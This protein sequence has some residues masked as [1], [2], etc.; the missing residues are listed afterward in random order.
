MNTICKHSL[1]FIVSVLLP[2]NVIAEG[3]ISDLLNTT[4]EEFHT[5]IDSSGKDRFVKNFIAGN[6]QRFKSSAT[7]TLRID[8]MTEERP[9][10]YLDQTIVSSFFLNER[11]YRTIMQRISSHKNV[12]ISESERLYFREIKGSTKNTMCSFNIYKAMLDK[13]IKLTYVYRLDTGAVVSHFT[14]SDQVCK[15]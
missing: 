7:G 8:A 15:S 11:A 4:V 6:N 3:S 1:I 5:H 14:F 13:G 12:S 2:K 9:K 10:A